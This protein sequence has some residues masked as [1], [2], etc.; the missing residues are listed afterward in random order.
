MKTKQAIAK[1]FIVTK[2]GKVMH[3]YAGQDHFNARN[4]GKITKKKRRDI[5]MEE[6]HTKTIK[7]LI[8]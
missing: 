6:T 7:R 2:K 4:T 8:A 3:R 5:A 1:R